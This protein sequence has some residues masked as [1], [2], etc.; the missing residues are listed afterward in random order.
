MKSQIAFLLGL[1]FLFGTSSGD[2]TF[3][4]NAE[5]TT[6]AIGEQGV[7]VAT[8]VCDKNLGALTPP[9]V[10]ASDAFTV[11]NSSRQGPSTFSSIEIIN[12]VTKQRNEVRYQFVYIITPKKSGTFV[13]PSLSIDID[14]KEV[15]TNPITFNATD[16]PV[17]N[18]DVKVFLSMNRHTLYI[19]EQT[20][21][22][23]KV[24]QRAHS[25]V[26]VRNGF[27]SA[28]EKIE[29][30]FGKAFSLNR[31]FTN[32][33]STSTERI[34]G[35][36]YNV[37][38]LP[39]IVFAL[40][41]GTYS[42]PSIPFEYQELRK[43]QR[44]R[45][46]PFMD[47]FFDSDF[48]G[49]GVQAVPK[50]AFSNSL[51]IQ[52][53]PL[54]PA[55]AGFTGSVGK[56]SISSSLEPKQVSAGDAATIKVTIKGNTRPNGIGDVILP[57]IEDCES[58]T[59]EKQTVCD[60]TA[61]G[62][63]SRKSYKYMIIPRH[64]GTVS[65]PSIEYTYFDPEA[66]SYKTASTE[67]MVLTVTESKGN[68]KQPTRYIS[69]EDIQQVG[70][71]IRYIKTD[72][73]IVNQTEAPYKEPVFFILI[74]I[75][76]LIFFLSLI[77]KYQS[78][79]KQK[80]TSRIIRQKAL[81]NALKQMNAIRKQGS[82]LSQTV[83]LGK[84]A[85]VIET[86]I[87]NKFEFAATGRTLEE[88]K[89]ELLKRNA[90]EK[91][92]DDLALFIQH[93][94][95]YRFGGVTFSESS[96][97]STIQKATQFLESLEKSIKKEKSMA[98]AILPITLLVFSG[99]MFQAKSAPMDSWFEQANKMYGDQNYDSAAYYYQKIINSGVNNSSV[100][101]N[102]GN[103]Y[104]RLKKPG[105]ARLY[106]EKAARLNPGDQDV[107]ANIRFL[108]SSIVDK[109]PEPERGFIESI[110]WRLHILLSLKAQLW[111]ILSLLTLISIFTSCAL[112]SRGNKRLWLLYLSV[113]MLLITGVIG[114]SAGI[115]INET[116]NVSYAIVLSPVVDAKNQ[117]EGNKILFTAHEGTKFLIRKTDDNWSLVSLPNGISGWVKNSDLGKI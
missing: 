1:F 97:S 64:K 60:T 57:K 68:A 99:F 66:G 116:E 106:Y 65:I 86:Y 29:K 12:G 18:A 49:G 14:G 115:K 105:L 56:F 20:T 55:P 113:L 53:K 117:P 22:S 39:F 27:S 33:V 90:D 83:F 81:S 114:I 6:I 51:S 17:K 38:S 59:P 25:S 98:R 26:D 28:L 110:L 16:E 82:A 4:A 74:P 96:R 58:F 11:L 77:Y 19:G 3:S 107:A 71:D 5:R 62:F 80:N 2:E 40:N 32:Q 21:M 89:E 42:I 69:Q 30:S 31:L 35:E 100:F 52:V 15:K 72:V 75:P 102:L 45:F 95:S 7:V 85:Q 67:P 41:Q 108:S 13:F 88:L 63:N 73:K 47:D 8:L 103:T 92:V 24:A 104:Y 37:Y 112:Y 46:D 10:N 50:T 61:S 87:S 84:V 76:F 54:P 9:Q 111:I 109:V 93:L 101:F 78:S 34:G 70:R 43:S 94:D 36:M 91:V 44:R 48:F 23:F 79:Q